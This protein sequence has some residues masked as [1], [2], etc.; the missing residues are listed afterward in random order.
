MRQAVAAFLAEASGEV[1]H[2]AMVLL[3]THLGSHNR[4]STLD[5]PEAADSLA[6]WC[7]DHWGGGESESART[8]LDT[9]RRAMDFWGARGWLA[10]DPAA[11]LR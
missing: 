11:K 3:G 8:A 4:L 7:Q 1:N 5:T 10:S 2:T 9:I 6:A